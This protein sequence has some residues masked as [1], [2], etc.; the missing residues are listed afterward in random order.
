MSEQMTAHRYTTADVDEIINSTG[1]G[2][3]PKK[4]LPPEDGRDGCC[5]RCEVMRCELID[6]AMLY[7]AE[8]NRRASGQDDYGQ[9]VRIAASARRLLADLG[10]SSSSEIETMPRGVRE[11][12]TAVA[13]LE[14]AT[15]LDGES[16][17]KRAELQSALRAINRLARWAEIAGQREETQRSLRRAKGKANVRKPDAAL[18]MLFGRLFAIWV[19]I[20]DR[21]ITAGSIVTKDGEDSGGPMI[22]FIQASARLLGERLSAGQVYE[23]IRSLKKS[24]DSPLGLMLPHTK[25]NRGKPRSKR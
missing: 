18:N 21:P 8:K 3:L 14:H 15:R 24:D 7:A 10:V 23:R 4:D 11:R 17:N 16:I 13:A 19:L 12:L 6:A 22:R 25:T 5:D 2:L 20:F 9:C 1:R